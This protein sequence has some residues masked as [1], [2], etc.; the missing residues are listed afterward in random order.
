MDGFT[1]NY[2]K[3]KQEIRDVAKQYF[4]GGNVS[5]P[6]ILP[7]FKKWHFY[8][9]LFLMCINTK[10]G[11]YEHLPVNTSAINQPYVTMQIMDLLKDLWIEKIKYDQDQAS[12][13]R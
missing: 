12:K 6:E 8:F 11:Y 4:Y 13:K 2:G 7:L 1:S 3:K 5:Q 10:N 9:Q